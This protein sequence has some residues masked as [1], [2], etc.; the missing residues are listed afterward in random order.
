MNEEG[1]RT[2]MLE[3]RHPH[4]H[5]ACWPRRNAAHRHPGVVHAHTPTLA[6]RLTR[7]AYIGVLQP[8]RSRRQAPWKADPTAG[9]GKTNAQERNTAKDTGRS[10]PNLGVGTGTHG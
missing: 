10:W 3:K 9:Q 4:K 5:M 1:D 8:P 2:T 7:P 6:L